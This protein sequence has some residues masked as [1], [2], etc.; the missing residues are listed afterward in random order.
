MSDHVPILERGGLAKALAELQTKLPEVRKTA[1]G[2]AGNQKTKYADLATISSQLLPLLGELGLSFSARPTLNVNGMF[3]LAYELLHVSGE[4]RTGEYPLSGQGPQAHGSAITYARRYTLCAVTG[5][6]PEDDDDDAADAQASHRREQ[7]EWEAAQRAPQRQPRQ[8]QAPEPPKQA[9][10]EPAPLI[11]KGQSKHIF[12]LFRDLGLS[13]DQHRAARMK[14]TTDIIG[15]SISS[16]AELTFN[17]AVKVIAEL[18][19]RVKGGTP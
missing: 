15:R 17:E 18:E 9:N 19:K 5:L 14:V 12:G 16:S 13:E 7:A 1:R 10:G 6:A 4:S 3:V 8:R 2:Q 11:D